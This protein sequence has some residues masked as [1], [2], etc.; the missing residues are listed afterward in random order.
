MSAAPVSGRP[1]GRSQTGHDPRGIVALLFGL[2]AGP[3]AWIT[4]LLLD[5]G[6]SSY[7]CYPADQPHLRAPPPGWEG[8]KPA[9][10]L[11]ALVC[12]ALAAAGLWISWLNWR[13]TREDRTKGTHHVVEVGEGRSCFLALCGMLTSAGFIVAIVAT[14]LPL[15]AVPSCWTFAG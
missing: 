15:F 13:R 6:L 1:H 12:L 3:T 14:A 7:A 10:A 4:Q 11:I 9:L 8:E 5:Y 2:A